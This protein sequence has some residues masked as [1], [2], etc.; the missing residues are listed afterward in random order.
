LTKPED[1]IIGV[2]GWKSKED[3]LLINSGGKAKRVAAAQYSLQGRYGVGTATWNTGEKG[4]L[5][6][7]LSGREGD[8]ILFL[9]R[10]GYVKNLPFEDVPKRKRQASG[11]KISLLKPGD[12]VE[13]LLAT[14]G[15]GALKTIRRKQSAGKKS[16]RRKTVFGKRKKR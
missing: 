11:K 3:I 6:G 2:V 14:P 5:I 9:L 10:T 16:V 13:T 1:R 7:A 15:Q 8:R 4:E 12:Q